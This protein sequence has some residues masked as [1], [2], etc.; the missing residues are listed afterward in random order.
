MEILD[1]TY[2][3]ASCEIE[4]ILQH[5]KF[6][7][8][9]VE[10]LGDLIDIVKDVEMIY[11]Y[12][13]DNVMDGYSLSN[14]QSNGYM[15]GR[16]GRM[17]P[18]MYNRSNSYMRNRSMNNGDYSNSDNKSMLIDGLQNVMNMAAD[19]K[20]RKAISRLMQQMESQ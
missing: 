3:R 19:E 9:D 12:Q 4:E 16:S 11:S 18:Y 5:Q 7:K 2:D 1:K 10:L 15:R 17:M 8:Q 20:D 6:D 14:G 13:D